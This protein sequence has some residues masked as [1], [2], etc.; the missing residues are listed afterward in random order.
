M[1]K[2]YKDKENNCIH[3]VTG[4]DAFR[5][6]TPPQLAKAKE[7]LT[8]LSF[9]QGQL[10]FKQ[11]MYM[12]QIFYIKSGFVKLYMES[13]GKL[14]IVTI[15]EPGAFIGV[16]TL[17]DEPA[18]PFTAEALTDT[19]V[20]LKDINF[21]REMVMENPEFAREMIRVLNV[22]IINSYRRLFSLTSHNIHTRFWELLLYLRDVVYKSN[23]FDLSISRKEMAALICTTPESVSRL[24]G[25]L[26]KQG[27][28][29]STGHTLEIVAS[30]SL[31]TN[32]GN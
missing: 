29:K 23:P 6:L 1:T 18:F 31:P 7:N 8:Q 32:T 5:L 28:I 24:I 26:K 17:F 2:E 16:Q 27:A 3:C 12:S 13:E 19:E 15:A 11:G 22:K 21:F 20:C 25:A 4:S 30:D 10:L 9:Q 14:N